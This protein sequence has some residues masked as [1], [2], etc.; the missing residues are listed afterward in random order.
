VRGARCEERGERIEER[1]EGSEVILF[2]APN[3]ACSCYTEIK[4]MEE[5][6]VKDA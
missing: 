3:A 6:I 4:M 5:E 2:S 1:G